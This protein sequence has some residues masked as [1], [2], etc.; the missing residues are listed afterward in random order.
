MWS[1]L[2]LT[3]TVKLSRATTAVKSTNTATQNSPTKKHSFF[4]PAHLRFLRQMLLPNMRPVRIIISCAKPPTRTQQ[5][6]KAIATT[7]LIMACGSYG[8][9]YGLGANATDSTRYTFDIPS[10]KVEEALSQLA[11]QT[12]HQ[13][14]FS[15]ALVN[16][17][18]S[19]AVTGD[20]SLT[21]ALQ[22]L[23]QTTPLTGHLTERGVIVVTDTS[24]RNHMEKGRGNMNITTKKGLL[25]GLVGVFAAGGMTQAVAQGGEA[26]TGQSAIDEIIV[27]ANKREQSLQDTAMSNFSA[28]R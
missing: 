1:T 18:N 27:T 24:A 15:Y 5:W 19:T 14:L 12:G 7:V 26:A 10:L 11:K 13:L 22:Q 9:V 16:S 6:K 25:A 23:L 4:S 21:S 2:F 20:H 8:P 28:L 17:H 3:K